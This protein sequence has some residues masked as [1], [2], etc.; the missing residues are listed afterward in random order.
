MKSDLRP[1]LAQICSVQSALAKVKATDEDQKYLE[2][3]LCL[4]ETVPPG[5]QIR[6][7]LDPL[8]E[9]LAAL[10][11]V[12]QNGNDEKKWRDFLARADN[13]PNSPTAI[14]GFLRAVEDCYRSKYPTADFFSGQIRHRVQV[15]V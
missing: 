5:E 15:H 4:I 9:Y 8:A 3:R 12:E 2:E 6:F 14:H 7:G 11:L 10:H 13:I 1:M